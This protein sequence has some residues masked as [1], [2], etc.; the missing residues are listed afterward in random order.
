VNPVKEL[1][2]VE[3]AI[4]GTDDLFRPVFRDVAVTDD[5]RVV[6][7]WEGVNPADSPDASDC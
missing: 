3:L 2:I 6:E 4:G 7:T 1:G 5:R